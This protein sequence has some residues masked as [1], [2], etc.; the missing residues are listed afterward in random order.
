MNTGNVVTPYRSTEVL[1]DPVERSVTVRPPAGDIR[2]GA[3]IAGA[4]PGSP[5]TSNTSLL[6]S[7]AWML[8]SYQH[9]GAW[10]TANAHSGIVRAANLNTI[11]AISEQPHYRAPSLVGVSPAPAVAAGDHFL[12]SRQAAGQTWQQELTPDATAFPKPSLASNY[13]M[14]RVVAGKTTLPA[15]TPITLRYH[16]PATQLSA[17]DYLATLYF[18]GPTDTYPK[19]TYRAGGYAITFKGDGNAS[20]WE[21]LTS[22]AT[23]A[24]IHRQVSDFR[25]APQGAVAG[26]AH[27]IHLLPH[28]RDTLDVLT[29]GMPATSLAAAPVPQAIAAGSAISHNPQQ[30]GYES[31]LTMTGPGPVR[32]DVRRDLSMPV[33]LSYHT[34][35][36]SGTLTD[37][38]WQLAL[39]AVSGD[40]IWITIYG[41]T[42][43][44]TSISTRVYTSGHQELAY[45]GGTGAYT[46][47]PGERT[48][49]VTFTLNS[50]PTCTKSPVI[51]GYSTFTQA[52]YQTSTAGSPTRLTIVGENRGVHIT[53]PDTEP[54]QEAC[55]ITTTDPLGDAA[56]LRTRA[57]Q[58]V[59]VQTRYDADPDHKVKLFEGK[60]TQASGQHRGGTGRP[61]PSPDSRDWD[62]QMTGQWARLADQIGTVRRDYL[63]DPA[64]GIDPLTGKP[65][66]WKLTGIIRDV[67]QL[68]GVHPDQLAI[69]DIP[70]RAFLSGSDAGEFALQPCQSYLEYIHRLVYDFLDAILVWDPN[71]G[72]YGQWTLVQA[73]S[74]YASRFTFRFT[75]PGAWK[76]PHNLAAYPAGTAPIFEFASHVKPPEANYVCVTGLSVLPTPGGESRQKLTQFAIN[77]RSFNFDPA[78]P[79]VDTTHPDYTDGRFR[80]VYVVDPSLRDQRHVD[81]LCYRLARH[82][83]FAQKWVQF[84]AP[85]VFINDPSGGHV[86]PLRVY[87]AV[88][89]DQRGTLHTVLLRSANIAYQRDA[90]QRADYEGI[91]VSDGAIS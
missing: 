81:I 74:T 63:Q 22:L 58:H 47:V 39:P 70:I 82:V 71:A 30:G 78:N 2:R 86:R 79:T 24:I 36:A 8:R 72:T 6:P 27:T 87:D 43:A 21:T 53:G 16:V 3:Q 62:L 18:G 85:L 46:C 60:L 42:P 33:Q 69:P 11:T 57:D 68:A 84:Q 32:L 35:P 77:P 9:E 29:P 5:G 54:D 10:E 45:N 44:G 67:F 7:G 65:F 50:D 48:Y 15:N 52:L 25:W 14:D 13:P 76:S 12:H 4:L 38:P 89:V 64:A 37:G 20:F 51:Y 88:T 56:I 26:R 28:G 75:G 80:P 17:Q 40:Q 1:I 73:P 34:Y 90:D 41:Y 31:K 23:L 61:Y 91:V 59:I 66:P 19:S 49:Y 83:L 55:S